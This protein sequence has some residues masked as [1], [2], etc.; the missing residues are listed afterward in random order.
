MPEPEK[1][2]TKIKQNL[3][4]LSVF[5]SGN[6]EN[7]T[8]QT[9]LNCSIFFRS[10]RGEVWG[11]APPRKFLNLRVSDWLKTWLLVFFSFLPTLT[12]LKLQVSF[13][14][15]KIEICMSI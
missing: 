8:S 6:K 10:T 12:Q 9:F 3:Q 1:S 15:I 14:S 7:L 2:Y 4:D 5:F 13:L 11:H